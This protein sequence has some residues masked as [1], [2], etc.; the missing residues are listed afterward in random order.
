MH[1][2]KFPIAPDSVLHRLLKLVAEE[3]AKEFSVVVPI[4]A[5]PENSRDKRTRKTKPK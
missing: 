2:K 3:V 5:K 1:A 4:S